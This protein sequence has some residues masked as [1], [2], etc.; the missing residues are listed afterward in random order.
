MIYILDVETKP[1]GAL[2][3]MFAGKIKA[4]GNYKNP[5][6]V[7]QY[8]AIERS[9]MFMKMAV[10][11]DYC[12]LFCVGLKPLGESAAIV[13]L[14]ELSRMLMADPSFHLVTFNGN[15]FDIPIIIKQGVKQGIVLPYAE[16]RV[17]AKRFDTSRH[18][19]LMELLS[20]GGTWKSLADYGKIYCGIE[21]EEIDF[22]TASDDEIMKHCLGDLDVTEQLYK[23]F[24]A[25]T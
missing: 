5:E 12:E 17:G 1:N 7:A 3:D 21:K 24:E 19:D 4:P 22:E 8:V 6:K 20:F 23:K 2:L 25:I 18:T 13:S 9:K 10:D 16:L 15:T 14:S 11:T